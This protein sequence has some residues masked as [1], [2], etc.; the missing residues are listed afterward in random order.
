MLKIEHLQ[1]KYKDFT[2]LDIHGE[3]NI[4]E[5]DFVGVIGANGAGKSTLIKALTDQVR[6]TG[7]IE[8]PKNI[9]V[10]LQENSY[11]NV[12]TCQTIME[13][14]LKTTLKKDEKLKSLIRFFNFQDMLRKKVT[15][16]SGGQKQRLTLIMVLYQDAPL[17][18]FDEMT[19]GLDFESRSRLMEKIQEWYSGKNATLLLVTH[20]FDEIEKL[21][22]KLIIIDK[23][24]LIEFGKTED[25]FKKY[26]GYSTIIIEGDKE[27]I[28]LQTGTKIVSEK[29]KQAFSFSNKNDQEEAVKELIM[30]GEKFS[31]SNNN[32]ELIYLNAINQSKQC[33]EN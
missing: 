22:N 5:N 4:K 21:A 8:K 9:A 10:H 13:G 27:N 16:L 14:L 17:T 31:I 1:V 25:L 32:I 12:L 33:Q 24:R 6:Y 11:P 20:Y 15:Q 3:I 23:G 19:A 18:C 29:G 7:F 26:V 30:L 28:V 2:A